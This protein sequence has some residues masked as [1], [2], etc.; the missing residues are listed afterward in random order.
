MKYFI[1][2]IFFNLNIFALDLNFENFSSNFEQKISNKNSSLIYKGDFIITQ[3]KAFWNY[4]KPNKKQIYINNKEVVIIEPELEQAIY[5]QLQNLPN[6]QKIFKQ[7][8]K[9]SQELYEA[10]YENTTYN[11][12]IKNNQLENISYKDEL[13]NFIVIYFYNQQFNQKIN[14]E[15]FIPKI[16]S[17]YDI[18]Q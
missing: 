2:F 12:K 5:T 11:I 14:S 15:I 17:H 16:P 7:A 13:E 3:N 18:I 1:F 10:K 4:T 9:I 8:K 6:L